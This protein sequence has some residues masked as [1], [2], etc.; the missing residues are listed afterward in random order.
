MA[1]KNPIHLKKVLTPVDFS[2]DS[3]KAIEYAAA[4]AE[5]FEG[6]VSLMYVDDLNYSEIG[7][8][9]IVDADRLRVE[10]K[11]KAT[12]KLEE[13]AEQFLP[14]A[15]RGE[16]IYKEGRPGIEI[17]ETAKNESFDLAVVSTHGHTGLSHILL[18]S[19][20]EYVVRHAP[21]PVLTVRTKE[22]D[23]VG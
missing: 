6:K 21:C 9:G 23:F 10:T 19:V 13:L 14:P 17:A 5:S 1:S 7:M 22:R 4:L 2:E 20:A 8:F 16:V 11:A 18:G 15:V 12:N 3:E